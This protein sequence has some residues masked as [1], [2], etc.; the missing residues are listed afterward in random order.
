MKTVNSLIE[1]LYV[2]SKHRL[3][4]KVGNHGSYKELLKNLMVQALIKLMEREV[5]VRCRKS[6]ENLVKDVISSA[7]DEYYAIL[8]KEV[9]AFKNADPPET[10]I[11]IDSSKYLPEYD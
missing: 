1:K 6:D 3:V 8:K 10:K 2:E 9:K 11:I 4:E 7:L 5:T